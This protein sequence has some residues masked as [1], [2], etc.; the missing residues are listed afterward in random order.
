M[1]GAYSV[2]F[3]CGFI[4]RV[5]QETIFKILVQQFI[6][7]FLTFFQQTVSFYIPNLAGLF[8][9]NV[10]NP[11]LILRPSTMKETKSLFGWFCSSNANWSIFS[12]VEGVREEKL[13]RH[14]EGVCF[15]PCSPL[16]IICLLTFFGNH[17]LTH[18]AILICIS[19]K[20]G[21][22]CK[23]LWSYT[24]AAIEVI[25]DLFTLMIKSDMASFVKFR[26]RIL[27]PL[28]P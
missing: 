9:V 13:P 3:K 2:R 11:S 6:N 19:Y 20:H 24:N 10:L 27:M 16:R 15:I 25:A 28:F 26:I 14:A 12:G 21:Q 8:G 5:I 7:C 1:Y 4:E 22:I 18:H 17:N 23:F